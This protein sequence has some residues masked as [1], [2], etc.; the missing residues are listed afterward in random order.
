M[1]IQGYWKKKMHPYDNVVAFEE[2]LCKYT[3]SKYCITTNSCTS[4]LFLICK[5][6]NVRTVELPAYTYVGVAMSVVNAGG[7]C[8]FLHY[9][10]SG[11]YKLRP[12][13]IID[14]ARNFH[15][16]MFQALQH[17]YELDTIY[18]CLSF[19][20]AKHVPIGEG[21]AILTNDGEAVPILKKMRYDGR[22]ER[23]APKDDRFDTLGWHM[24][25]DPPSAARGLGLMSGIKDHYE[26]L[27]EMNYT[28]LSKWEIFK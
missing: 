14:S 4:A 3:G 11:H 21:G 23:T 2:E 9:K 8:K 16:G 24:Y 22:T 13:P 5:Y 26:I 28:D 1:K 25:L 20:I 6:L 27:P 17:L 10:W 18:I 12:Y 15:K 19:H 7:K